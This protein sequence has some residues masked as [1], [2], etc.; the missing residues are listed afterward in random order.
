M[1][2]SV[3]LAVLLGVFGAGGCTGSDDDDGSASW[4]VVQQDLSGALLSVWGTSSRDVW[5][6][7]AD[8]GDGTGPIV[9]HYDGTA[10]TRM[11]TGQTSGTL[12]WVFGFSSGPIYMGG[13][14]GVI[15]R[16]DGSSFTKMQTPGT[17]TIFGIW[18]CSP[19]DIW[20]VGG[21]SESSGG[22]AWHNDGSSDTWT[23]E[24]SVPPAAE[25][26]AIWKVFGKD[27]SDVVF[28]GSNGLA[29]RWNGQTLNEEQTGVGSSLF[30]IKY[31][32][33]CYVA[34]GG[35]ASGIIFENCGSG[36][37]D[38]TPDPAPNGLAGVCIAGSEGYAVGQY[39]A[40][41]VRDASGWKEDPN[42]LLIDQNLHG[43]WIDPS[44]GVWAVGGQTFSP[45]LTDGV[46]IHLG[47][48]V[49]PGGV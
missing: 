6:V 44:G 13:D 23:A 40:V 41:Y 32:D 34:V 36:W 4:Q 30:T 43:V 38:V 21:D 46:M 7:G 5:A 47:E 31:S 15:L 45:P 19:N 10:W 2:H 12:W 16:Y 35:L 8:A 22:L 28:V 3:L 49:P 1:R 24:P 48:R 18:G 14:G 37:T 20:A 39:G 9:I 26:A 27:C 17:A 29:L 25:N 33:G 11:P 42:S